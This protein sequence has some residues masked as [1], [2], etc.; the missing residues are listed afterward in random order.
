[1]AQNLG[2]VT[3]YGYA[4]AG[5]Y[6]GTEE[7]FTTM[8]GNL[9]DD[10]TSASASATAAAQSANNASQ[11][12][13]DA[14][15]AKNTVINAIGEAISI[16]TRRYE[17]KYTISS[18]T[19]SF[20]FNPSGYT[21]SDG[22][23]F[24]VYINGAKLVE[25][26][27]SNSSN[28]ITL[29]SAVSSGTVEIIGYKNVGLETDS[30]LTLPDAAA[31][32][33]ATGDEINNL[34]DELTNTF[35]AVTE[36]EPANINYGKTI[37]TGTS[38]TSLTP[39]NSSDT[40]CAVMVCQAGEIFTISG[41]GWSNQRLWAFYSP[42]NAG[43]YTRLQMSAS[44]ASANLEEITAPTG[45]AYLVCNF[46][47]TPANYEGFLC[48]GRLAY[49]KVNAK[50]DEVRKI[51]KDANSIDITQN[52]QQFSDATIS[53]VN[54]D[55]DGLKCVI[56]GTST[57]LIRYNF[58]NRGSATELPDG[59]AVGE[60]YHVKYHSEYANLEIYGYSNGA[61]SADL[62]SGRED[63]TFTIPEGIT[64]ILFQMR[65][66]NETIISPSEIIDFHI[67][68]AERNIDLSSD[69]EKIKADFKF[70]DGESFSLK[71]IGI[72]TE[73]FNGLQQVCVHHDNFYR[74]ITGD[75]WKIGTNGNTP[76]G[77]PMDY[78]SIRND[79]D[80]VDDGFRIINNEMVNDTNVNIK[81]SFRLVS[82][83]QK[84]SMFM[85]EMVSP[86][87]VDGQR[88]VFAYGV[89][90]II[91]AMII[92]IVYNSQYDLYYVNGAVL[93]QGDIIGRTTIAAVRSD[94]NAFRMLFKSN[95]VYI[96]ADDTN[97]TPDGYAITMAPDD[98][99]GLFIHKDYNIK[100]KGFAVYYFRPYIEINPNYVLD[101]NSFHYVYLEHATVED[102]PAYARTL[103]DSNTRFSPYSER[104]ELRK[105]DPYVLGSPRTE[106]YMV[107]PFRNNLRKM[108]LSFDVY[109]DP[110]F[111]VDNIDTIIFQMHDT[112]DS[113]DNIER[114]PNFAI[115]LINGYYRIFICGW[116]EKNVAKN[117]SGMSANYQTIDIPVV[118]YETGKW[119]HFEIKIKEGYMN[120][121]N[122]ITIITKDN[123]LMYKSHV[124]NSY[125][126]VMGSYAKYGVYASDWK[127]LPSTTTVKT[128]Y[129]DNF[130]YKY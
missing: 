89:K 44:G 127:V 16:E 69:V 14:T 31:D 29:S 42:E 56:S 35:N 121:H 64:G 72:E 122:P 54:F 49:K 96:Y 79:Y 93:S 52:I 91:N 102:T 20:T 7:E 48:R 9:D 32:A 10:A 24:E 82:N 126:R 117:A 81:Y 30:T 106:D 38:I 41:E 18:S 73:N 47:N 5:G 63:G 76:V 83:K 109:I 95:K 115:S 98:P 26:A 90:S 119:V 34:K 104:F 4:K 114:S 130:R 60:T 46:K 75:L 21:Y 51:I 39:V 58:Y 100:V 129:V 55:W 11:S 13:T 27:Y 87:K 40:N 6:T 37:T 59:F 28:V 66:P 1:M 50:F 97:M 88:S 33:K 80:T 25:D 17:K 124:L 19:S 70:A 84:S 105:N 45:S 12:A 113:N 67:C 77:Y 94:V 57:A 99:F 120:E 3:A 8:I 78:Y 123:E 23:R 108:V 92:E 111:E 65:I 103:D 43:S 101:A 62:F 128:T 107:G 116:D 2:K 36:N 118:E 61:Y 74:T 85:A 110:T 53:G 112:P 71:D 15:N 86:E 68:T 125:N 22:D